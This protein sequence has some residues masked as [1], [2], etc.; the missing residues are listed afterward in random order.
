VFYSS[1]VPKNNSPPTDDGMSLFVPGVPSQYSIMFQSNPG[2]YPSEAPFKLGSCP[3]PQTLDEAGKACRGQT[4]TS[5]Q[6]S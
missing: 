2:S 4:L 6:Y 1:R 5:N 3:Y